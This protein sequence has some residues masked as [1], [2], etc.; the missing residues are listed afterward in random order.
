VLG[1]PALPRTQIL[2]VDGFKPFRGVVSSLLR[3]RVEFYL[4]REASDGVEGLEKASKL[5]PDLLLLDVELSSLNGIEVARRVRDAV[6]AITIIF[7]TL[8]SSHEVVEAAFK[9]GASGYVNKLSAYDDLQPAI[10][11]TL[12]GKRF[13]SP[14]LGFKDRTDAPVRHHHEIVFCSDDEAILNSLTDYVSAAINSNDG[15]IACLTEV[16]QRSL[17]ERL[18]AQ[19]VDIDGAIQ[20]GT[21]ISADAAEKPDLHQLREAIRAVRHAATNAGKKHPRVAVCGERAG[22]LWAEG[23]VDEALTLEHLCSELAKGDDVDILC[24][25][26]SLQAHEDDPALKI[27]YAEHSTISFQSS[28]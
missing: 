16:H 14:S 5:A 3:Q 26:P 12:A 21:Y 17:L 20:R 10:D 22:R 19:G 25:Y 15:A 13:I 28:A 7:L 2:I 27:I 23:K 18:H 24:Q 4:I 8:E 6:P 1:H 11:A 9:A